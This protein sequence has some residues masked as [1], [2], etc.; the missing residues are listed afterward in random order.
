[1]APQT[2]FRVTKIAYRAGVVTEEGLKMLPL[3]SLRENHAEQPVT[4]SY[5]VQGIAV[6]FRTK[7]KQQN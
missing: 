1:M 3:R 2:E 4:P 7:W 5:A 6:A